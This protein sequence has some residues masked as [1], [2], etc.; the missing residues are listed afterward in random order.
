MN[1]SNAQIGASLGVFTIDRLNVAAESTL[2][3]DHDT[4]VQAHMGRQFAA[5]GGLVERAVET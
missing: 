3:I 4:G 5:I 1:S 2:A